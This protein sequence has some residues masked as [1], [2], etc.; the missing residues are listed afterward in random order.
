MGADAAGIAL[1]SL[2]ALRSRSMT[3]QKPAA[4]TSA[5]RCAL[6]LTLVGSITVGVLAWI[7]SLTAA[8]ITAAKAAAE[9]RLLQELVPPHFDTRILQSDRMALPQ[10]EGLNQSEGALGWRINKNDRVLLIVLPWTSSEGYGGDISGLIGLL[11]NG[12]IT[13]VR[14]TEHRETPGLGDAIERRK[15]DWILWF[16]GRTLEKPGE[17]GWFVRK[18]GAGFDQITGATITPRAVVRAVYQ[19]LVYTEAHHQELF[20]MQP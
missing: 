19:A 15:S 11:P 10:P 2:A 3:I 7:E 17:E 6:G 12:Q 9:A 14:V 4:L 5:R 20:A 8:P 16:T 1:G 13:G 18:D